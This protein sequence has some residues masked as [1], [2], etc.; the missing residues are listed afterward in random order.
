MSR[1]RGFTLIELMVA[2]AILAV[3]MVITLGAVGGFFRMG[4]AQE[5]QNTLQQ[6]FRFAVDS[7]ST[8]A[9]QAMQVGA[10]GSSNDVFAMTDSVSFQVSEAGTLRWIRYRVNESGGSGFPTAELVREYV[11][12]DAG[13]NTWSPDTSVA[14]P[15]R[16]VT[17]QIPE[18]LKVY[19]I[20]SG[21]RLFVVMVGRMT[22]FNRQQTVSLVSLVYARNRGG[23]GT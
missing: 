19:F 14:V 11:T 21:N 16:P 1:R 7:I 20:N 13:T 22:Y 2:L 10:P 15:A 5:Q 9:R 18:L 4:S 6:N 8:D 12:Y 17:E 3:V 23:S